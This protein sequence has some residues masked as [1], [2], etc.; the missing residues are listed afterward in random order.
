MVVLSTFPGRLTTWAGTRSWCTSE[1]LPN[2]WPCVSSS[3]KSTSMLVLL[4]LSVRTKSSTCESCKKYVSYLAHCVIFM[5]VMVNKTC[6]RLCEEA[7]ESSPVRVKREEVYR[8][9]PRESML[10]AL[11]LSWIVASSDEG[12]GT[13]ASAAWCKALRFE[14]FTCERYITQKS[15]KTKIRN[16]WFSNNTKE[17]GFD[18]L[19][20][21]LHAPNHLQSHFRALFDA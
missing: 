18:S 1:L 5:S 2:T 7:L 6:W 12:Y 19:F 13:G 11:L 4:Q 14:S 15:C 16:S 20:C 21:S 3:V 10:R 8:A 17:S 9:V